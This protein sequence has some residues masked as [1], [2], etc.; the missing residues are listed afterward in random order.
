M[1]SLIHFSNRVMKMCANFNQYSTSW[2]F[3]A[4]QGETIC[5]E[6]PS[7]VNCHVYTFFCWIC[8]SVLSLENNAMNHWETWPLHGKTFYIFAPILLKKSYK[9]NPIFH[10]LRAPVHAII[11]PLKWLLWVQWNKLIFTLATL[12]I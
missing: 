4:Q 6:D 5:Q 11:K 8:S 12:L 9:L 7:I 2:T 1:R 3:I 10:T